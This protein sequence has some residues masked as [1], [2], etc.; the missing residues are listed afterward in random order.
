MITTRE[1]A[2]QPWRDIIVNI[3][4][5]Y[6]TPISHITP[7]D[8]LLALNVPE[9]CLWTTPSW[10]MKITYEDAVSVIDYMCKDDLDWKAYSRDVGVDMDAKKF[11]IALC[12]PKDDMPEMKL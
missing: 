8:V 5:S 3:N 11:Y 2:Y 10:N 1:Y 4:P 12:T 7:S 6:Y 9:K